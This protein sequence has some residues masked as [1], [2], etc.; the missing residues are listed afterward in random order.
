MTTAPAS[1]T[2]YPIMTF[3]NKDNF[4]KDI[5]IATYAFG[6]DYP[7]VLCRVAANDKVR[8][9]VNPKHEIPQY[10]WHIPPEKGRASFVINPDTGNV[11]I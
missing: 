8:I 11:L 6:Y 4:P 1:S 10:L 5:A 3:V 2:T 7:K 9:A